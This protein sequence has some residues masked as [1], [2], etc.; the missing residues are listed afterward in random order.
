MV[1]PNCRV[2]IML[3]N[4]EK[5]GQGRNTTLLNSPLERCISDSKRFQLHN[6]LVYTHGDPL[7]GQCALARPNTT[8]L[9]ELCSSNCA[10]IQGQ[11]DWK[12]S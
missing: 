6:T 5:E 12:R 4:T 2:H 7:L 1:G 10:M 8:I 9:I 3:D 11:K